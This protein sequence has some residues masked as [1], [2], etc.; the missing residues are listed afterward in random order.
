M[1]SNQYNQA[2]VSVVVV[3]PRVGQPVE[4]VCCME[5]VMT[6]GEEQGRS[7]GLGLLDRAWPSVSP[8]IW[9]PSEEKRAQPLA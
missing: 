7:K 6:M 1:N 9:S 5:E 8:T 4:A 3:L 2:K